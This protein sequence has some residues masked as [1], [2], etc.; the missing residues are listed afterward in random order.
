MY[1]SAYV[2]VTVR[3]IGFVRVMSRDIQLEERIRQAKVYLEEAH[4]ACVTSN[5]PVDEVYWAGHTPFCEELVFASNEEYGKMLIT[6][7][8]LQSTAADEAIYHEHL[9]HPAILAYRSLYGHKPLRV[10]VLGVSL[11]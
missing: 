10:L 6:D 8:E 4:S 9:V 11:R 7:R 5:Y 3:S 2:K 1:A